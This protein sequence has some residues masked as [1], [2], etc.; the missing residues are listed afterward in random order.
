M[1]ANIIEEAVKWKKKYNLS[2]YDCYKC[3]YMLK[4][5]RKNRYIRNF[6]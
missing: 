4:A 3:S 2:I 6:F 5:K 1:D